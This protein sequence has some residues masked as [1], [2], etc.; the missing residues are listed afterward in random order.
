[1]G[2]AK[3]W[4][5]YHRS[6]YA[7]RLVNWVV[8]AADAGLGLRPLPESPELDADEAVFI[9]QL[10]GGLTRSNETGPLVQI[11]RGRGMNASSK[12]RGRR[13]AVGAHASV[14][15]AVVAP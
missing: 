4:R 11:Q 13:I 5:D 7:E 1:M 12:R 2:W 9:W 14:Q 6:A 8:Q 15:F 3:A 10:F